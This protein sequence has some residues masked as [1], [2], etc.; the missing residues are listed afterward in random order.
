MHFLPHFHQIV[1]PD[2]RLE[3]SSTYHLAMF[4]ITARER[5]YAGMSITRRTVGSET[6]KSSMFRTRMRI[7]WNIIRAAGLILSWHAL[8]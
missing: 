2:T 7:K 5:A 8:T 3:D 6:S 1:H 4:R